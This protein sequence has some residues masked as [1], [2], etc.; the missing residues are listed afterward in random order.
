M[1]NKN[2]NTSALSVVSR[3]FST[4]VAFRG[5]SASSMNLL[6]TLSI[7]PLVS[8]LTVN[9]VQANSD[10]EGGFE[11]IKFH[12]AHSIAASFNHHPSISATQDGHYSLSW[13]FKLN[14][15]GDSE[16]LSFNIFR[17][18]ENEA[19]YTFL[20]STERMTHREHGLEEGNYRYVIE[21]CISTNC[22]W[23]VETAF[24]TVDPML[25][26]RVKSARIVAN[27]NEFGFSGFFPSRT[28]IEWTASPRAEYYLIQG[29]DRSGWRYSMTRTDTFLLSFKPIQE[30]A[31]QACHSD[32][33]GEITLLALLVE[34]PPSPCDT[35]PYCKIK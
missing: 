16:S 30:L 34:N 31:I 7:F 8:L 12:S 19:E 26:E 17:K 3:L 18:N 21:A 5:L 2:I 4:K 6:I 15:P 29:L 28:Q 14:E 35:Y 20:S 13:Q 10:S 11:Q 1:H 22:Q 27:I 32:G 33:C 24:I 23:Q 25:P 9:N